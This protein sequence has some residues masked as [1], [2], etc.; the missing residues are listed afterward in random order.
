MVHIENLRSPQHPL[1]A[2]RQDLEKVLT[3][4]NDIE[5]NMTRMGAFAVGVLVFV[6]CTIYSTHSDRTNVL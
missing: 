3:M 2:L 1:A 4:N 6:L 5:H